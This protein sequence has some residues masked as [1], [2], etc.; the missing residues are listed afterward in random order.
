MRR[1]KLGLWGAMEFLFLSFI[2]RKMSC[3][4]RLP[5][6]LVR[7]LKISTSLNET[8]QIGQVIVMP[9]L[10]VLIILV[11]TFSCTTMSPWIKPTRPAL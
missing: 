7:M 5:S 6:G 3:L 4:E 2:I 11:L 1:E 10:M 9:I 8:D